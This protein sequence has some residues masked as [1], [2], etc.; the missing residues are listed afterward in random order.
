MTD[1]EILVLFRQNVELLLEE[2]GMSQSDLARGIGVRPSYICDLVRG[3][4]FSKGPNL[5]TLNRIA[6]GLGVN[7]STLLSTVLRRK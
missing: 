4:R 2:L 3:R 7:V 1:K 6:N 5:V